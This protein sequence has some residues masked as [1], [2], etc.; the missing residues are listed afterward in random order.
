MVMKVI[1]KIAVKILYLLLTGYALSWRVN[2]V[3][4]DRYQKLK[5]SKISFVVP[6]WHNVLL[7]CSFAFRN[8]GIVTMAS[9]S[10]DG[11]VIA[12]LMKMWGFIPARGSSSRGGIKATLNLI[13]ECN[14]KK[15]L[16]ALTVDG[17]RG[18]KYK[19]KDGV[20]FIAKKLD[21]I[22]LPAYATASRAIRFNSWD[23]FILPLPFSKVTVTFMEP[24]YLDDNVEPEAIERDRVNLEKIM[25]SST[26]DSD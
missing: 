15:S 12:G 5:D 17:P 10:K 20:I 2:Y 22:V 9:N 25:L 1:K 18:P 14:S 19:V 24:I 26:D 3:N 13:K 21:K 8:E 23:K 16:T 11:D 7:I 6:I 4:K